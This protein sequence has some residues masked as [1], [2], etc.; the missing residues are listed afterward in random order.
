MKICIISNFYPPYFFGGEKTI[1]I[2][3]EALERRGHAVEVITSS[4]TR[5][6]YIEEMNR[7]KIHRFFPYNLYPPFQSQN[8]PIFMKALFHIFDLWNPYAY[9]EIKK[10]LQ[11]I[12]PSVVYIHNYK[13]LSLAAFGATKDLGLP[14]VFSAND[15]SLL[16]PRATLLKSSGEICLHPLPQ[17]RVYVQVQK[18]IL[19]RNKPNIV[20]SDAQHKLDKLMA[21]GFFEG[22][23]TKVEVIGRE[24][25]KKSVE[26][27]HDL[28]NILYVG[29]VNKHKG[30]HVL[31][32]AFKLLRQDN[33]RLHIVGKGQNIVE[34]KKLA[35]DD[36]RII[37]HGFVHNDEL[38]DMLQRANISVVPS[39][40]YDVASG[41]ICESFNSGTPVIGS[42]IGGIP[43]LIE[44]KR[45]GL[46]FEAGNSEELGVILGRLIDNPAELKMLE[47]GALKSREKYDIE[48]HL[49]RMEALFK[50][51]VN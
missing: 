30:V 37:F 14:L 8:K 35:G 31:I 38:S 10:T 5:K 11:S 49:D 32:K 18:Q 29:G 40:W 16:C 9:M 21:A 2:Q 3:A 44:D 33:V 45:N 43:E 27:H 15:F 24:L 13:G 41:V 48:H 26:K 7:V 36:P 39:I 25:I 1:Q 23:D 34:M 42:R 28:V 6:S 50:G 46:L 22:V 4:P 51:L 12:N 47:A 17:C 20:V 19:I